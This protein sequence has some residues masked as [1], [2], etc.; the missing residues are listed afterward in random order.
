MLA[1]ATTVNLP[2]IIIGGVIAVIFAAIVV[3]GIMKRRRGE[4]GCGCVCSGCPNSGVCHGGK[5]E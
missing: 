2:T 1:L 5:T 4:T 3:R